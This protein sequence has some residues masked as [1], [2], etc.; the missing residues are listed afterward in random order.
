VRLGRHVEVAGDREQPVEHLADRHVLHRKPAD[1]LADGAQR[2]RELGDIV[3]RGHIARLEMDLGD[4]GIIA[5]DQAVE[6]LGQP[7]PRLAVDAAHDA[8]VDRG[9]AP[10]GER[11]QI[12]LVEIGMEE[13]VRNR[14]AQERAHQAAGED[15]ACRARPR[16]ALRL[17]ELDAVDPFERQHL[18]GGALPVDLRDH[19]IRLGLH[20]LGQLR[21]GGGFAA[22]IELARGPALEGLDDQARAQARCLAAHALDLGGGPFI[23][24][25]RP[26]EL[27]LDAGAE[28]LYRDL[29]AVGG[30]CAVDLRDRGGADGMLVDFGEKVSSGRPYEAALDPL[31]DHRKGQGGSASCS[32]SRSCAASSPTRSGRVA[33]V[34]PSLIA[35][36]PIAWKASA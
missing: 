23:G 35:A 16:P 12:A 9:D 15:I 34:W 31:A 30:D 19:E 22:Q 14:L 24:V 26:G 5:G 18:A 1:R 32:R 33:S 7:Q 21:G 4:A 36:G 17:R 11:E 29:A 20:A 25:D 27:G 10:V 6:D 3:V 8:E 2:R 13:A 28:H